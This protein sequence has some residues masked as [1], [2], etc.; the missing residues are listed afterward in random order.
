RDQPCAG[1]L[2]D[3]ELVRLADV[4]HLERVTLVD[5]ALEV[6]RADL[7]DGLHFFATP[8]AAESDVVLQLLD[9]RVLAAKRALR[10]ATQLQLLEAHRKRVVEQQPADERLADP[11]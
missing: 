7:L 1:N 2:R 10:V 3:R 5:P 6:G 4:D 8:D 11:E 9:R